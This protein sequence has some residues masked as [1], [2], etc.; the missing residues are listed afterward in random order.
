MNSARDP[1]RGARLLPVASVAALV[2]A[3]GGAMVV[4]DRLDPTTPPVVATTTAPE[5]PAHLY[6]RTALDL[7]GTRALGVDLD[8]WP[9]VRRSVLAEVAGATTPAK[10]HDAIEAA[11]FVAT[12]GRGR[13]IRPHELPP[14][15]PRAG[16]VS[17][18][19]GEGLGILSLPAV[20]EGRVDAASARATSIAR[21]IN[22]SRRS[23]TCGWVIDLRGTGADVDYGA[24]AGLS[25]FLPEGQLYT[26]VGRG[27][28]GHLVTLAMATTFVGA[29]PA[30]SVT[31]LTPRIEQPVAVLQ[32]ERT[33]GS[34]EALVL[35]LRR[36]PVVRT[37]G[38]ATSGMATNETFRLSDGALL[39]L[40]TTQ[41]V[42]VDGNLHAGG[43]EP[44]VPTGP[45]ATLETAT[46]WLRD[47]CGP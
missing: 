26:T 5:A 45:D 25:A 17:V 19:T 18:R 15:A 2:V 42:G 39:V 8:T 10:T 46:K 35:S 38:T 41:I 36:S 30:A 27:G 32:D 13:L 40:P 44:D 34:S 37:F 1:A 12:G 28:D 24:I 29:R 3:V 14:P 23:V 22:G 9:E 47:T 4:L 7:I 11:V 6:A 20:D 33:V 31:G 21:A 43:L 16:P